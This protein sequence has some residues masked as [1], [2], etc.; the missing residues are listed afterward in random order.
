VPAGAPRS[1]TL[2]NP[3]LLPKIRQLEQGINSIDSINFLPFCKK[4][5]PW[6]QRFSF[7]WNYECQNGVEGGALVRN[8]GVLAVLRRICLRQQ[9]GMG[10]KWNSPAAHFVEREFA[11][12]AKPQQQFRCRLSGHTLSGTRLRTTGK[13]TSFRV[14]SFPTTFRNS[15]AARFVEGKFAPADKAQQQFRCHLPGHTF[16]GAR[17]RAIER[18]AARWLFVL[19]P[20]TTRTTSS[21]RPFH[22]NAE[23]RVDLLSVAERRRHRE[24]GHRSRDTDNTVHFGRGVGGPQTYDCFSKRTGKCLRV[25]TAGRAYHMWRDRDCH[26]RTHARLGLHSERS[27]LRHPRGRG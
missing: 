6:G 21:T 8:H 5:D 9:M 18:F 20:I 23:W 24:S 3:Q 16:C 15:P 2:D 27:H 1:S 14:L 11:P 12:A 17:L 26:T 22:T 7:S 13:F 19:V 4:R 25:Q 10:D